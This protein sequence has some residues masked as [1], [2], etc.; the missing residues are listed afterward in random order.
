[1]TGRVR[2]QWAV[3]L[4]TEREK[5]GWSKAEMARRLRDAVGAVRTPVASINRQVYDWEHGKHFPREWAAAYAI[6]FGLDE[7]DL[8]G[9]QAP[10][11]QPPP[12]SLVLG[13]ADV[14]GLN[15]RP[16]DADYVDA[17]RETNQ[18]LVRLDALWGG[19]EVFPLALR[20]FRTAH[21]KLGARTY[22]PEV[23]RDLMAATGETGEVTAWLAY[24]ADRQ[25]ASRQLIH[26]AMLLS[27]Q[28][29]DRDMELFE[30]SHL[31]MQS[32]YLLRPAEAL[33][34]T[35]EVLEGGR[36]VPRVAALFEMRRGRALAQMGDERRALDALDR[37]SAALSDG[38]GGRDPHWTWWV[39]DTEIT[40]HKA[41]ARAQLGQWGQAV[42]L[43]ESAADDC[44]GGSLYGKLDLAQLLQALVEVGDWRRAE[45]IITEACGLAGSIGP[46]R[47]ANLFREVVA[48]IV[49]DDDA[50]STV[51]DTAEHLRRLL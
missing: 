29:G 23:E 2:P 7:A 30:L 34:I 14:L 47:A 43:F 21:P 28:A 44:R 32:L 36:L 22:A 37:A 3:R 49:R 16:V 33:R 13:S 31:A 38:V 17:I 18:A 9:V 50:P 48:R 12:V 40:R 6:A 24:D 42:P 41:T 26:E 39:D 27:R 20:V 8:F 25:D 11:R 46:G 5:R 35:D 4:Q 10:A 45:D 19:D 15:G 51:S 1:M